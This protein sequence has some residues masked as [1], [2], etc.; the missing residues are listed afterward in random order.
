[1]KGSTKAMPPDNSGDKRLPIRSGLSFRTKGL[2]FVA[3]IN[4]VSTLIFSVYSYQALKSS[5]MRDVDSRLLTCAHAIRYILPEGYHGRIISKDSI[6]SQEYVSNIN[7]LSQFSKYAGVTYLYTLMESGDKIVFTSTSA[8][9]Q[10]L[11]KGTFDH[12]FSVYED[13]TPKLKQALR[14]HKV[15]FEESHDKYGDFRSVIV[16]VIMSSEKVYVMGADLDIRSIKALLNQGLHRSLMIGGL[17]FILSMTVSV[18]FLR[19]F[20]GSII[21]RD[22]IAGVMA[23]S[24]KI[25]KTSQ[26]LVNNSAELA[27]Y[28]QDQNEVVSETSKTLEELA[29]VVGRN[30]EGS[31][32]VEAE[33]KSFNDTVCGRMS[34]INDMNDSMREIDVSSVGIE[35]IMGVMNEIAFQTNL[36]ALNASVEVDRAGDA[37]KGFSV[38]A[39]EV[40]N[41]A[42]KTAESSRDIEQIVHKN[43]DVTRKGLELVTEISDFFQVI[44]EQITEI[45]AKISDITEVS[46]EQSADIEYISGAISRTRDILERNTD[47]AGMLAESSRDLQASVF[48]LEEIIEPFKDK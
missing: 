16:P 47:L 43:I 34:L 18:V 24:G 21:T 27:S 45:V 35:K 29:L 32:S 8:T 46:R 7:K 25:I 48:S 30:T 23:L 33:L 13:A 15:F 39:E 11:K 31:A 3:L 44:T 9:A 37:G 4:I 5:I 2:L 19:R 36:L 12:F 22:I 42:R 40:R 6:A 20:T 38:V 1:M 10:E 14:D 26:D 41:L 17:L 28:T